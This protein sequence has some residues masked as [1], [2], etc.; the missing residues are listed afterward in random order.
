MTTT[1][2]RTDRGTESAK[3]VHDCRLSNPTAAT[4]TRKP[5]R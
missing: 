3:P 2:T 5:M 1:A 4:T